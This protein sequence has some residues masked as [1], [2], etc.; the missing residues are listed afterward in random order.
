VTASGFGERALCPRL[1]FLV[2]RAREFTVINRQANLHA[3]SMFH[4]MQSAQSTTAE[5]KFNPT[6]VFKM[7]TQMRNKNPITQPA[8]WATDKIGIHTF[9]F[10]KEMKEIRGR[11]FHCPGCRELS[12]TLAR[13]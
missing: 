11:E 4:E 7:F 2:W 9:N 10:I 8:A 6:V 3:P 12:S 13:L 1:G 5:S